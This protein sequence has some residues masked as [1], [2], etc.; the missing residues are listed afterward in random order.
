MNWFITFANSS[1]G[2]KIFM[3]I[4]GLFLS[5]FLIIHLIG[6]LTLFGGPEFF[7]S[8]VS[9]LS[10]VRP[11]VRFI[12][13]ILT[14]IF[15]VHI[16]N[17]IRIT[18]ENKRATPDKYISN[19]TNENSSFFSRNMGLTGSVIFI[20]LAIHLQTIWYQFQIQHD[21]GHFYKIVMNN[22]I[23]FGNIFVTLL[24]S[25]AM[26]LLSFHLR[27]GFQSAFQTFGIRYNKY[28]KL[29]EWVAVFFWLIIPLG[30]LSIPIYFGL[31]KG[32]F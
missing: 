24:Y 29:I 2:K 27:H 3:A 4:T 6:N 19:K 7:N 25:I 17:G 9:T 8:Y 13:T 21:G 32:G 16:V 20:F 22:T 10:A 23:G 28:G 18:L 5:L 12:E 14:L 30:F 1:I 26:I 11:L 31:I 15:L